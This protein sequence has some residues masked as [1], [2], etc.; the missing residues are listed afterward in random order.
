MFEGITAFILFFF[1]SFPKLQV[2]FNIRII[3]M[4][5]LFGAKKIANVLISKKF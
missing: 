4:K 5:V 2:D 3:I 1:P